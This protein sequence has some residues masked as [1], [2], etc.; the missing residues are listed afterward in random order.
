MAAVSDRFVLAA[1]A[2]QRDGWWWQGHG[3]TNKTIRRRILKELWQAR[4][5]G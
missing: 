2:M 1:Q 5:A 4:R 3:L